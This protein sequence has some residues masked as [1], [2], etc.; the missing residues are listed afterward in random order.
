MSFYIS[1]LTVEGVN[2]QSAI[3][4]FTNGFNLICGV[5]NS[6]K[7]CILKSIQFA[8]GIENKPFDDTTTGYNKVTLDV[9]S[10]GKTISVTRSLQKNNV[11][12]DSDHSEISSGTYDTDYKPKGNKN[13]V[14]NEVWLKLI[15][16][17]GLPMMISKQDGTRQRLR[18]KT[19]TNLF[20][21]KEEKIENPKSV[22]LPSVV[23]QH[24]YFFACL[25]FLLTGNDFSNFGEQTSKT[26]M[27]IKSGI[28]EFLGSKIFQMSE[29]RKEVQEELDKIGSVRLEVEL[30]GLL[31][32]LHD[33]EQRILEI[34][35]ER[36][37]VLKD[38]NTCEDEISEINVTLTQF[39]QLKSQYTS[40]IKRLTFIVESDT[41]YGSVEKNTSCPF[42]EHELEPQM[43]I[44]YIEAAQG[45]LNRIVQLLQGLVESEQH[46]TEKLN[47]TQIVMNGLDESKKS[48]ESKIENDLFPVAESLKEKII[49]YR[50]VIELQ[51]EEDLLQQ[52]STEWN[53]EL[54]ASTTAETSEDKFE[55]KKN[56]PE[57]FNQKMNDI[58]LFLL[59]ECKYEGI[60][61]S[62][63]N[64]GTFDL[65]V[66]GLI[67]EVSHGKG[68]WAYF[69][70]ILGLTFRKLLNTASEHPIG[71]FVIDTPLL[72]LDQ[73]VDDKNADSMRS[74]LFQYFINSQ[75]EGQIIIVDNT[76]DLPDLD[77][78]GNDVNVIEFTHD[79][80]KSN[81]ESRYGFLYD[82][83]TDDE[84]DDE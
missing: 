64:M 44:S 2:K 61:T 53:D 21:L 67:K 20:W 7:T 51:H 81:F 49:S 26:E 6:G 73:G 55:P 29:K 27:G 37:A 60:N 58:S 71:F 15:G 11:T 1:K 13:P 52:I 79:K 40:D 63:F 68:Y 24:P 17:D 28:E 76:K 70:T 38:Y 48:I 42:C 80:Y 66:N 14:L 9:I 54:T 43:E 74:A 45:E 56:F 33:V 77:Y 10:A 12:I 41:N 83:S 4:E 65:E 75:D 59:E 31:M 57:D 34:S 8:M 19:L 25:L 46:L 69:N 18:W 82:V 32:T 62:R 84:T 5:S 30:E 78:V 22:I 3:V 50:K 39:G 47:D 23:T 35:K 72:G 36:K 16:I